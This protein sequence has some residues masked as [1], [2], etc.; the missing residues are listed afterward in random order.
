MLVFSGYVS[1]T[2]LRV[3][4]T[5]LYFRGQTR[6]GT[7]LTEGISYNLLASSLSFIPP[8]PFAPPHD[9][10]PL[11]LT[12]RATTENHALDSFQNLLFSIARFR[13]LTSRF[14]D[15]ITIVGYEMK[16][17]RFEG[18]HCVALR[19]SCAKEKGDEEREEKRSDERWSYI[20]IDPEF[21][22]NEA[23]SAYEG[24]VRSTI[25]ISLPPH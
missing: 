23:K 22:P 4:L 13:E 25:S 14:P 16:R 8:T 19:W 9:S 24:E 7:P 3:E 11:P 10:V 5:V 1:P 17:A 18:V 20:G 21:E 6:L 12:T 2:H 15:R